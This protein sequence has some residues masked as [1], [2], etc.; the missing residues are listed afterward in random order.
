[1]LDISMNLKIYAKYENSKERC[2]YLN[3]NILSMLHLQLIS[4][5]DNLKKSF[6]WSIIKIFL[7][8]SVIKSIIRIYYTSKNI[9]HDL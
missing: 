6:C 7:S 1:M 4:I 8:N 9:K 3:L 2:A 5:L